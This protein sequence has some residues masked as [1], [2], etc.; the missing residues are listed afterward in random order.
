MYPRSTKRTARC[1]VD[2]SQ[3]SDES[4]SGAGTALQPRRASCEGVAKIGFEGGVS[5]IE[6]FPARDDNDVERGPRVVNLTEN[7]SNQSFSAIS[8]NRIPELPRCHDAKP[9]RAGRAGRDDERQKTCVHPES[10][11]ENPLKLHPATEPLVG[12]EAMGPGRRRLLVL[13]HW[14]CMTAR[15]RGGLVY[16]EETVKRFRPLARRRFR[17]SRPFL[18]LIRT[19]NP[20]VR[21]RRRRFGWN[22]RFMISDPLQRPQ[23]TRRNLDSS[24]ASTGVSI[25]LQRGPASIRVQNSAGFRGDLGLNMALFVSI[26]NR[27]LQSPPLPDAFV[28]G[29]RE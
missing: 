18:V 4:V 24:E 16:D 20:W 15:G 9:R 2:R 21:R 12:A 14:L 22:V 13:T 1:P 5:G 25:Q 28:A 27:M 7:L 3:A 23:S 26:Q 8:L 11:V 10:R 17:T 6:Q 19:R 29:R